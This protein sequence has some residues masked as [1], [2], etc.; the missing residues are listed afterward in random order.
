MSRFLVSAVAA[1]MHSSVLFERNSLT[2]PRGDASSQVVHPHSTSSRRAHSG[3][4]GR[5]AGGTVAVSLALT[6]GGGCDRTTAENGPARLETRP[7][8][9][10]SPGED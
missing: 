2:R 10:S 6:H 3:C 8:G 1:P 5:R 9:S 4:D 7:D